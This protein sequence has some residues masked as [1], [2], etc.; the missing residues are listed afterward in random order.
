MQED[1]VKKISQH[2]K[3]LE[4]VSKR[5][6]FVWI[7][8]T[9]MLVIYYAFIL[10]IAFDPA[11]LGKPVSE[12]MVTSIGIPVGMLII[13]LAFILTGIYVQRANREFD[14]LTNQIKAEIK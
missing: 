8:S 10:L 6:A 14:E 4:L 11:W 2:P 1:L 3:Y 9:I 13:I 5:R 12:G 7:L